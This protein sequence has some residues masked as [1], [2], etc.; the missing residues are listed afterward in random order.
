MPM[1]KIPFAR[2]IPRSFEKAWLGQETP[3][4]AMEKGGVCVCMCVY[5]CVCVCVTQPIPWK[6][7]EDLVWLG[8]SSVHHEER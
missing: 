4:S 7:L 2:P 3:Q 6:L 1:K 5:V 8:D